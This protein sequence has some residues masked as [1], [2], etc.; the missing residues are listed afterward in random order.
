MIYSFGDYELDTQLYELRQAGKSLKVEPKVF[1]VLAYLVQHR[2]SVVSK[3]ELLERLWPD[4]Y[5]SEATLSGCITAVR[6]AVGDTGREQRVIQTA[7]GRGYR[8]VAVVEERAPVEPEET[9]PPAAE[10]ASPVAPQPPEPMTAVPPAGLLPGPAERQLE[11]RVPQPRPETRRCEACQHENSLAA[12]FCVAC[13]ARLLLSCPGC[14]QQVHLPAT[15]CAACGQRLEEGPLSGAGREAF[16]QGRFVNREQE[17]TALLELFAQAA[18]GQ[19]RVV[20]VVGEPAIGKS[21]L[22]NELRR[23]LRDQPVLYLE[24]RC[25]AYGR[26]M[27]LLPILDLVRHLCGIT[28]TEPPEAITGKVYQRLQEFGMDATVAGPLLLH[29]LG[30]KAAT[31]QLAI[32]SPETLRVRLFA[33]LR[34]MLLACSRQRPLIVAVEDVHWIDPSSEEFLTLLLDSLAQVPV[35]LLVTFQPEYRPAWLD[36][37][38]AAV[39]SLLPLL[40]RDSLRLVQS[41]LPQERALAPLVQAILARAAGHPLFLEELTRAIV[42]QRALEAEVVMPDTIRGA[43]MARLDHLPEAPRRLLQTAAV[44]GPTVS[45]RLLEAIWDDPEGLDPLLLELE[46][47][48]LCYEYRGAPE[49]TYVFKHALLQE[50]AYKSLLP[51]RRRTI[52]AAVGQ[53]LER[54]SPARAEAVVPLLAYHYAQSGQATRAVEALTHAAEHAVRHCAHAEALL[55]LQEALG[56]VEHLPAE[57]QMRYRLDLVLRQ[58]QSL[59]ALSRVQEAILLLQQYARLAASQSAWLAGRYALLLSQ[60]AS[61]LGEWVQ[62]AQHAQHAVEAA[63]A[64]QDEETLG[65][66][67]HILATERY[68]AG[69]PLAGLAYSQQ[70]VALLQRAAE[71]SRLGMAYFVLG[72][73]ALLLGD[74]E[75]ALEAV[76]QT[77]TIGEHSGDLHLRAFAAWST[78]W[79]EATRGAWETAIAACQRALEYAPDPLN[80]A[81]ALGWLGYAYLEHGSPEEA[82]PLLEEASEQMRQLQ[83]RR[84]EGLYTIFLGEASL[85]HGDVDKAGALVRQ[86]LDIA[87]AA[88]YRFGLGWGQR[89]LGRIAQASTA[90]TE[91]EHHLRQALD[92][93]TALSARFEVGRTH[94][95]L[96]DVCHLQ[97]NREAATLHATEAHRLFTTLCVPQYVERTAERA[98]ELGLPLFE[99]SQAGSEPP[100]ERCAEG[101]VAPEMR[102]T[103]LPVLAEERK[104]ATI[105]LCTIANATTL[106]ERLGG[107]GFQRLQQRLFERAEAELQRYEGTMVQ[108]VGS[109]FVALFGLPVAHE[110]HAWQAVL[111]AIGLQ[112]C[113]RDHQAELGLPSGV[114]VTVHMGLHTEALAVPQ[115]GD[116]RP[117]PTGIPEASTALLKSLLRL[118]GPGTILVSQTTYRLVRNAVQSEMI[119]SLSGLSQAAPIAVYK[120]LGVATWPATL[121]TPGERALSPFVGRERELT[122]LHDLLARAEAG[123]GQVVGIAGETGMGKSRL[124]YEFRQRLHG[125]RVTYLEGHCHSHGRFVPYLPILDGLRYSCGITDTDSPEAV[126]AKVRYG[127]QEAG[128]DPAEGA[129]YLLR[130]LG[131]Q[132]GTEPLAML[133][134][135]T[136]KARTFAILLQMGLQG[137]RRRPLIAAVENL[138]WIDPTSEEFLTTLVEHLAGAPLL[139]LTTYRPGYRPPWI[140]KSYAT[141]IA[142]HR[143]TDQDCLTVVRSILQVAEIPDRLVQEILAKAAGNPFFLEELALGVVESGAPP[144]TLVIPD[145]IQAVLAARID[146]LPPVAKRLL[147]MAA[148]IGKDVPLALLHAMA[149]LPE[150]ELQRGLLHLQTTEFLHETGFVPERVYTFKHVLTRDVAYQSLLASTRQHLHQRIAQVLVERLPNMAESQPELLAHHYTEAG[151]PASA[152]AYWQRAGQRA[153]ERSALVEA[154]AHLT[155]GLEL[156]PLLPDTPERARQELVLQTT[157]GP[158]LMATRGYAAP[159]VVQAYTRARQLGQQVGDNAQLLAALVGLQRYYLVRG[160][161]QTARELG[162]QCLSLAQGVQD[163]GLLLEAHAALGIVLFWIGEFAPSRLHLEQA[164]ALYDP[165]QHCAAAFYGQAPGVGYRRYVAWLLWLLGYPDQALENTRAALSLAQELVHPLSLAMALCC[166]AVF[167]QLR[168]EVGAAQERAE[169]AIALCTEQGFTLYLAWGTIL[170]G[171]AAA[172]QGQATEGIAQMRQGMEAWR[173]TGAEIMRPYFL[174]LLAEAYGKTGRSEEGLRALDEAIAVVNKNTER[175]WEAEVYR[176]RGE[177]LLAQAGRHEGKGQRAKGKRQKWEE[178]E[179]SLHQALE[180]A[181]RQGARL[182]EL[183]AVMSLY[184]LWQ[185]QGKHIAAHQMLAE[186]YGQCTEGFDTADL[187]AAKALLTV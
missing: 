68:W 185:R 97:G 85:Q 36:T 136:V 164:M 121:G 147:Q 65:Q 128:I 165:Q 17:L 126:G 106:S 167:H 72:L 172:E 77:R 182:L 46:R 140:D 138:H 111:A 184:R 102:P 18:R 157:L 131:I 149:E 135:Q 163:P 64:C 123:Q 37:A 27:P 118:A 2:D 143:L 82:M 33:T 151:L 130:L 58:A 105:L 187:Q 47:R 25:R 55:T 112:R 183:R 42:E 19:G 62:A 15:F 178:A 93:F 73:N 186:V 69:Q 180:M 171:W 14:G 44:L 117:V 141:Q 1:D 41:I 173:A 88:A 175:W 144:T 124:L 78:G 67:Y 139:L 95:A 5:I 114:E 22:L 101:R 32:L 4:Q 166:A 35:L 56:L 132:E 168:R 133:P 91:A 158:A 89:A 122:V 113:L 20:G 60:S 110:K 155:R 119:G 28:A 94:L 90:L 176:L 30:G 24:G 51:A 162:E 107:E 125:R 98:R 7:H 129:P 100:A 40:P 96:A 70:A 120:I 150:A 52:H 148:V 23:R 57:A 43:L 145:S 159:E 84:L 127:L 152:V 75:R 39:V 21:W 86:G 61:H 49:P 156:L 169:A 116:E 29:L 83:Y 26:A 3:E 154:V 48:A 12:S 76:A 66:A 181:R 179:A 108:C 109:G 31:D 59:F 8:F 161:L 16:V 160:E 115:P 6:K 13:G 45:I 63:T 53:A 104:P 153:I 87:A 92:T 38:A 10:A 11:Q 54:L 9:A 79:T 174:T 71:R 170:R 81:F 74:F 177:L 80:T 34:Q 99:T 142:L 134:P 50:V 146:R 103:L 137:S